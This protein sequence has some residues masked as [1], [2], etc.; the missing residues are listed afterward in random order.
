MYPQKDDGGL[1]GAAYA[2]GS[3]SCFAKRDGIMALCKWYRRVVPRHR[4]LKQARPER[5]VGLTAS[6]ASSSAPSCKKLTRI[7]DCSNV[8][9]GLAPPLAKP[10]GVASATDNTFPCWKVMIGQE[11]EQGREEGPYR[12]GKASSCEQCGQIGRN[13]TSLMA[14]IRRRL[15]DSRSE[16]GRLQPKRAGLAAVS[17]RF[18]AD[19]NNN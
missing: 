10:G 16:D 6:H 8:V 14:Y 7:F 11:L 5:V 17:H 19:D 15:S 2:R 13:P 9:G 1:S 4:C 12:K 18:A 3:R